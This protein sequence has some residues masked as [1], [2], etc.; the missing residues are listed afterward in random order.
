MTFPIR[1]STRARPRPIWPPLGEVCWKAEIFRRASHE[2]TPIVLRRSPVSSAATGGRG[3]AAKPD[4]TAP[5]PLT[6]P[7]SSSA[8]SV[9][10]LSR[11]GLDGHAGH[12]KF[13]K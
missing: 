8:E 2:G 1:R 3:P 13:F 5:P 7:P 6:Q 4:A 10:F 11:R 9:R 12:P